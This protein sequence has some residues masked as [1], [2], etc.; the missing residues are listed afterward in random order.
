MVHLIVKSYFGWWDRRDSLLESGLRLSVV[1]VLP[2]SFLRGHHARVCL[3][4]RMWIVR[5]LCRWFHFFVAILSH[6]VRP[7]F[8][9]FILSLFSFQSKKIVWGG[10]FI[11]LL[12]AYV[13]IFWLLFTLLKTDCSRWDRTINNSSE[14]IYV[15]FLGQT[16][17]R[18]RLPWS[19]KPLPKVIL[20]CFLYCCFKW[21]NDYDVKSASMST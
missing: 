18:V 14:V 12:F 20:L 5:S 10:Q 3:K 6:W 16:L 2:R 21:L 15:S 7:C 9:F 4:T 11:L 13:S 17:R 8:L 1:R 19:V